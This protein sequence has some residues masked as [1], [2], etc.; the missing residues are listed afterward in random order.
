MKAAVGDFIENSRRRELCVGEVNGGVGK[1]SFRVTFYGL[2]MTRNLKS[3]QVTILSENELLDYASSANASANGGMN[4]EVPVGSATGNPSPTTVSTTVS[5]PAVALGANPVTPPRRIAARR[6]AARRVAAPPNVDGTIVGD[7]IPDVPAAIGRTSTGIVDTPH[8]GDLP[9]TI[10]APAPAV[11]APAVATPAVLAPAVAPATTTDVATATTPVR[12]TENHVVGGH[13]TAVGNAE[14]GQPQV[15]ATAN[16]AE[17]N[18][19]A[20]RIAET[21]THLRSLVGREVEKPLNTGGSI[22]WKVVEDHHA[23]SFKMRAPSQLGYNWDDAPF[24]M[25]DQYVFAKIFLSLLFDDFHVSLAKMNSRVT[26]QGPS[27][28][29]MFSHE[30]FLK[31]LG[32]M[33]GAACFHQKGHNLFSPSSS[34]ITIA[35]KDY[36]TVEQLPNFRMYMFLYCWKHFIK[37][38]PMIWNNEQKRTVDPWWKVRSLIDEFNSLRLKRILS[39]NVLVFDE[40]MIG[41]RPQVNPTGNIPHLTYLKDK[42]CDLGTEGKI[43]MCAIL[44]TSALLK[45]QEGKMA[46][47]SKKYNPQLGIQTG[48]VVRMHEEL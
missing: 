12:T 27:G 7:T 32:I 16:L 37:Y 43:I 3:K 23:A 30:E 4:V 19:Y 20:A 38:L 40:S 15:N 42:P 9:A 45:I 41:Y 33:I 29:R 6:V 35:G 39:S 25:G 14:M 26:D 24:E 48:C 2:G 46:M 13:A 21:R 47:A 36:Y 22:K 34:V 8:V 5:L 31:G 10:V 17:A 18:A 11:L 1:D 28:V 44:G